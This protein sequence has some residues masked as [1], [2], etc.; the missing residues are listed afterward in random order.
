MKSA[1]LIRYEI[2]KLADLHASQADYRDQRVTWAR[3][4]KLEADHTKARRREHRA[5]ARALIYKAD[6]YGPN[7]RIYS[8][9]G[10]WGSN[11]EGVTFTNAKTQVVTSYRPED[12]RDGHGNLIVVDSNGD[13]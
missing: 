3:I 2:R 12:L 11:D 10:F 5:L 4:V 6:V 1:A 9:D 13:F 7:G 8:S